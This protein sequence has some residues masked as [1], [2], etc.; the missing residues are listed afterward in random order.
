M[1]A[2][3]Y[4]HT[5]EFYGIATCEKSW[6]YKPQSMVTTN[7]VKILW[8][9]GIRTGRVISAHRSDIV[10]HDSMGCSAILTDIA[11]LAD[12]NIIDKECEKILKHVDLRLE[13]QKIWNHRW[14]K[15]IPIVIDALGSFTP[16][17][18][19]NLEVLS[20]VHKIGPLLK[21]A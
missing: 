17:L 13:L 21:A 19:K 11:I 5:C 16:I 9:V 7:H 3:I 12:V 14:I 15:F 20:G 6:L 2:L 8:D 10:V 1:A 18:P 4:K